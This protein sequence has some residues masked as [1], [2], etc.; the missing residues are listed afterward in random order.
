MLKCGS[1]Q[2]SRQELPTTHLD[3]L[4]EYMHTRSNHVAKK[5]IKVAKL[6]HLQNNLKTNK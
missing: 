3:L 6:W 2:E 5:T 1:F 4:K